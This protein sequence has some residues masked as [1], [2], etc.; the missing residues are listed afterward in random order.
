MALNRNTCRATV[1]LALVLNGFVVS[2]L[3]RNF[4]CAA[5]GANGNGFAVIFSTDESQDEIVS[6]G[7]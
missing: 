5:S 6:L 4:Q 2:R 7:I 1:N 3:T